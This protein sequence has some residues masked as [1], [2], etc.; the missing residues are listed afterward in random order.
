MKIESI[1]LREIKMRLKAPFE[2]SFGVTQD[3]RILL[4]EIL[5][6]G[7]AGWGEVTAME[8]PSYNPET[9][10]TA[11]HVISDFLAPL[12]LGRNIPSAKNVPALFAGIRGHNMAKAGLRMLSTTSNL[13]RKAY[14]S[15]NSWEAQSPRLHA[16]FRSEY[17]RRRARCSRKV[18]EELGRGYQRI[19]LKIKPGKDL[20]FVAAVRARYPDILLSVDANSAYHPGGQR[21]SAE[22]RLF[23]PIDDRATAE[24]GMTFILMPSCRRKSKRLSAW[25]NA[26]TTQCTLP[27][28]SDQALAR[29]STLSSGRVGRTHQRSRSARRVPRRGYTGVVR[30]HAGIGH[31]ARAQ[32][33]NV[34]LVRIHPSRGCFCEQSLLGRGRH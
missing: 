10:D 24:V 32:H 27:P 26:L 30:R 29:S 1:T 17:E 15:T 4:V 6:E 3:R 22:A 18:E 23:Q 13:A 28:Q 7:V 16:G 34:H 31:W 5:A 2:T 14:R 9:T 12:L 11:W 21:P 33:C 8:T 19:K 20:E 25:T